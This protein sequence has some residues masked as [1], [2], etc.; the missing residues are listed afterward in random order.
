MST[1]AFSP[2]RLSLS[3]WPVTNTIN[4]QPAACYPSA[5][6]SSGQAD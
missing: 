6:I 5:R 3:C 4:A 1:T 2:G